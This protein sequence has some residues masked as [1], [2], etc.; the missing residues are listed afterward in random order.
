MK[1]WVT[2]NTNGRA[3]E[4]AG[5]VDTQETQRWK[6]WKRA[7]DTCRLCP[8]SIL[9]T[10]QSGYTCESTWLD[11]LWFLLDCPEGAW[12][13]QTGPITF[14]VWGPLYEH[15]SGWSS[16]LRL[17]VKQAQLLMREHARQVQS[18]VF[19][20]PGVHFAAELGVICAGQCRCFLGM[21]EACCYEGFDS[22]C[23][24]PFLTALRKVLSFAR[25]FCSMNKQQ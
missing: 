7:Y 22:P 12:C 6:R 20:F 15:T 3:S 11:L 25:E 2:K 24:L 18:A 10:S 5:A 8:T 21:A 14:L 1:R 17:M 23:Q 19:R 16:I 4:V 13:L 9:V